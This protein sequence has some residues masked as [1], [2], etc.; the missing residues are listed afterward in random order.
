MALRKG[1]P[2]DYQ[3]TLKDLKS[4]NYVCANSDVCKLIFRIEVLIFKIKLA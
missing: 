4:W 1:I 3:M 2:S